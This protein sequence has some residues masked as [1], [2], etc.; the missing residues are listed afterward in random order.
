MAPNVI[1]D[2]AQVWVVVRDTRP[3]RSVG[4]ITAWLAGGRRR[5]RRTATQTEAEFVHFFGAHDLMPNEPLARQ[6]YRHILATPTDF[7]EEEHAFAKACQREM[8]VPED[9]LAQRP[10]A[11]PRRGLGRRLVRPRRRQLPGAD[12]RLRLADAC[13]CTSGCTPGR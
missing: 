5:A 10:A 11:L 3:R 13:R 7:T 6:L 1:P 8:G 2:F 9:G 4:E 12:R